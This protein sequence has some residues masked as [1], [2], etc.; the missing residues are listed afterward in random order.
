MKPV[1]ALFVD[2]GG[3]YKALLGSDYCWGPDR[4]ARLYAG[5]YPVVAHPPCQL[6]TNMAAVNWKRY[7][8]QL[9]AWYPGGTDEECFE[10]ALFA[11]R[12][13][14]GV[15]EHPAYS[16]AWERFGL[17]RPT[18]RK[19]EP[20]SWSSEGHGS[21]E[22]VSRVW[23]SAYDHK[24]AKETWLLCCT[25]R[26]PFPLAWNYVEGT[27]QIGWFDR[28]KPTLGKKEASATPEP[29]A[30]TLIRLA[31]NSSFLAP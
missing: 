26:R 5:P 23:Q 1:V 22:W 15:L 27:H 20:S 21:T 10:A 31:G 12:M 14:G 16:R 11:V 2:P 25:P 7:R 29:F 8:R 19:R 30:R 28:N 4:D 17:L 18:G 13:W 9:P 6:W 3:I 24:A